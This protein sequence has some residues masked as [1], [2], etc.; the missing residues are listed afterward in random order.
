MTL[1]SCKLSNLLCSVIFVIFTI[2]ST[3]TSLCRHLSV[4]STGNC[5]LGHDC[6]RVCLHHRRDSFVASAVCS[7]RRPDTTQLDSFVASTSA[8][9]IGHYNTKPKRRSSARGMNFCFISIL[10]SAAIKQNSSVSTVTSCPV[11]TAQSVA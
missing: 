6:R 3:M 1:H 5:K 8:V 9:C 11:F 10:R 4:V 7:H 2:F